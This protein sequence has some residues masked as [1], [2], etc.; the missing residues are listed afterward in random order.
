[1]FLHGFAAVPVAVAYLILV[2]PM[3]LRTF[4]FAIIAATGTGFGNAQDM[5]RP[6]VTYDSVVEPSGPP[7]TAQLRVTN[8]DPVVPGSRVDIVTGNAPAHA[9]VADVV[10]DAARWKTNDPSKMPNYPAEGF[11]TLTLSQHQWDSFLYKR[12]L[13]LLL[14]P[15]R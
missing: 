6:K 1:M 4:A 15:L 12:D 11:V 8:S 7:K 10:V 5:Q 14:H 3:K 9:L 2:R 13:R